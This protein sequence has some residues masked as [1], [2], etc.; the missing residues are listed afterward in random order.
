MGDR[1][2]AFLPPR[3]QGWV[4]VSR[5]AHRPSMK[6]VSKL[7]Q[8]V[9]KHSAGRYYLDNYSVAFE[10]PSGAIMFKLAYRE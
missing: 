5:D 8:L 10:L 9:D 2:L 4:W 3:D 1:R 6:P 7:L